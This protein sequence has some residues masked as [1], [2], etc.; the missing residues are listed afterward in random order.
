MVFVR[1]KEIKTNLYFWAGDLNINILNADNHTATGNFLNTM[2]SNAFHPAITK[3]TRINEFSATIIDNIFTNASTN[4]F[5]G[6]IYKNISDH[7][8]IFVINETN[9]RKRRVA[10]CR[11]IESRD[12]GRDNILKLQEKFGWV[13]FCKF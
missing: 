2:A 12:M 9:V 10:L 5:K 13:F 1:S 3:P 8:P 11:K 6:I 4:S 7:L